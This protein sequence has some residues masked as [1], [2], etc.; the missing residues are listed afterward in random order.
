MEFVCISTHLNGSGWSEPLGSCLIPILI[1]SGVVHAHLTS[2]SKMA[3]NCIPHRNSTSPSNSPH[4]QQQMEEIRKKAQAAVLN[5]LPLKLTFKDFVDEGINPH[6]L[7]KVF[8]R[9]GLPIPPEE[10]VPVADARIGLHHQRVALEGEKKQGVV[11]ERGQAQED[12]NKEWEKAEEERKRKEKD[13]REQEREAKRLILQEKLQ[14]LKEKEEQKMRDIET[15]RREE[16]ERKEREE[17][18]K[19]QQEEA[20]AL[21]K[22]EE[23][24]LQAQAARK[25]E[26]ELEE[27]KAKKRIMQK[28]FEEMSSN[29]P[30]KPSPPAIPVPAYTSNISPLSSLPSLTFGPATPAPPGTIPGLLLSGMDI[31]SEDFASNMTP[32]TGIEVS[33]NCIPISP[34]V[35]N[36]TDSRSLARKKRP[37]AA[38]FDSEPSILSHQHKRR[39]GSFKEGPFI[40]ELTEDED[41]DAELDE[42]RIVDSQ[43]PQSSIHV[44]A[45]ISKSP[46][47]MNGGVKSAG[48]NGNSPPARSSSTINGNTDAAKQLYDTEE[49]IR[50]L[51]EEIQAR[52]GKKKKTSATATPAPTGVPTRMSTPA[53]PV[54]GPNNSTVLPTSSTQLL[55]SPPP[56]LSQTEQPT[57][58][59]P[60]LAVNAD[61]NLEPSRVP[62]SERGVSEE[63]H[64]T[65]SNS[66]Q[67]QPDAPHVT[68]SNDSLRSTQHK[69]DEECESISMRE[70]AERLRMLLLSKR[71]VVECMYP[72]VPIVYQESVETHWR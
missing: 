63:Q 30:S 49:K 68:L 71:K 39:F 48:R 69:A 36:H 1:P 70:E 34:D 15:K 14:K 32:P 3:P 46:P 52:Q 60:G 20:I 4:S 16:Q 26:Q 65:T 59:I 5:L 44:A 21:K 2:D 53:E 72:L 61:T 41:E 29:L 22:K 10:V 23:E 43:K 12:G 56:K 58:D 50:R 13:E 51:R 31:G 6:I 45:R 54:P 8:E 42:P 17:R 28:K 33:Q 38:D 62:K 67:Q 37:V 24:M 9:I 57:S 7:R 40:F 19:K 66:M 47:S 35:I 25:K 18:E 55:S 64:K 11:L 27:L